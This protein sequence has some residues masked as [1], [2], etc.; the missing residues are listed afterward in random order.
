MPSSLDLLLRQQEARRVLTTEVESV[1][2]KKAFGQASD[3]ERPGCP[4][5]PFRV[6]GDPRQTYPPGQSVQITRT[7]GGTGAQQSRPS[8]V[9]PVRRAQSA[10]G[11]IGGQA[12]EVI[13]TTTEPKIFWASVPPL[14]VDD[15]LQPNAVTLNV[16]LAGVGFT[17]KPGE[18]PG[19]YVF[20][21]MR[22]LESGTFVE[23]V[24]VSI[25]NPPTG[26]AGAL[27]VE[28]S[29]FVDI[30]TT[31]NLAKGDKVAVRVERDP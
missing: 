16:I 27:G 5:D 14:Y 10:G 3:V 13:A 20:T 23:H 26:D 18:D 31:A 1:V 24:E 15:V 6:D 11:V 21:A 12:R 7:R 8:I 4:E 9:T 17:V 2:I 28:S 30:T 19:L 22:Q 25:A 29:V